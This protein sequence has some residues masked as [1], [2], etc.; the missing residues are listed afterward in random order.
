MEKPPPRAVPFTS[1]TEELAIHSSMTP[2]PPGIKPDA[3]VIFPGLG[4]GDRYTFGIRLREQLGVKYLVVAGSHVN[5]MDHIEPDV[6]TLKRFGLNTSKNLL[7]QPSALHTA[8]QADWLAR[9]AHE[10]GIKS[11]VIVASR[12]HIVRAYLTAIHSMNQAG[13]PFVLLTMP[14]PRPLSSLVPQLEATQ[15]DCM[16]GEHDR[17]PRFQKATSETPQGI[18]TLSE[19]MTYDKWLYNQPIMRGLF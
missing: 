8:D 19:A 1:R 11:A 6:D 16:P 14:V 18:A 15:L 4:E 17:I 2:L 13:K 10:H 12:F 7:A 9:T 5:D 3:V